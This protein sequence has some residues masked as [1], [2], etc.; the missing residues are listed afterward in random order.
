MGELSEA[1]KDSIIQ[2]EADEEYKALGEMIVSAMA[3]FKTGTISLGLDSDVD[4]YRNGRTLWVELETLPNYPFTF[5]IDDRAAHR[6][7]DPTRHILNQIAEPLFKHF[8]Y[9]PSLPVDDHII[10]GEE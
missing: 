4:F 7:Y 6:D 9:R 1:F 8:R 10:L 5:K 2:K 3:P